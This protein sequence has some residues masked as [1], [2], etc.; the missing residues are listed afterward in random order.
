M[1]IVRAIANA[2]RWMWT[3]I[4]GKDFDVEATYPE[5]Y[6]APSGEDAMTHGSVTLNLSQL[7]SGGMG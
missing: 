1:I 4:T 6:E 3:F 5:N 2:G 7:G